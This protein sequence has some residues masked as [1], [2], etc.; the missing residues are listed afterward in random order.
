MCIIKR[1][2]FIKIRQSSAGSTRVGSFVARLQKNSVK[3]AY[4]D[5]HSSL[6]QGGIEF[7]SLIL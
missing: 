3:L 1:Y 2:Q 7:H 4:T 6:Y 5:K